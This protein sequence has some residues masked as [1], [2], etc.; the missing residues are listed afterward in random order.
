M[1]LDA[2]HKWPGETTREW[3]RVIVKDEAVTARV[4]AIW[5][6]LGID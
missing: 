2:T 6:E 4:D 1:R 3:G 5:K